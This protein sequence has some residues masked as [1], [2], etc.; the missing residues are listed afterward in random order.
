[1]LAVIDVLQ[2]HIPSSLFG[3]GTLSPG[4]LLR[5]A[6]VQVIMQLLVPSLAVDVWN[7]CGLD[8]LTRILVHILERVFV[9]VNRRGSV[10][11]WSRLLTSELPCCCTLETNSDFLRCQ[12]LIDSTSVV[13]RP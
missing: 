13:C 11:L 7:S 3:H 9:E 6:V 4:R 8:T 2:F 1:M 10:A 5:L 12:Q